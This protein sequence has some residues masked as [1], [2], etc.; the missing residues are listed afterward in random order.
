MK[1]TVACV[2]IMLVAQ[3]FQLVLLAGY[4]VTLGLVAGTVAF[5]CASQGVPWNRLLT[6]AGALGFVSLATLLS[7][8]TAGVLE[9]ARTLALL[10]FTIFV[11]VSSSTGAKLNFVTSLFLRRTLLTV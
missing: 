10:L 1:L 6:V 5:A 2:A 3:H 7:S 9:F 8:T 11:L 4:P